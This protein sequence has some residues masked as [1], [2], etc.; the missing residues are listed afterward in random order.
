MRQPYPDLCPSFLIMIRLAHPSDPY[1]DWVI[2]QCPSF[3]AGRAGS[4]P[5]STPITSTAGTHFP[6]HLRTSHETHFTPRP[7]LGA[8]LPTCPY[9]PQPDSWA[10]R[11]VTGQAAAGGGGGGGGATRF[12]SWPHSPADQMGRT[13]RA[14]R[15]S[16]ARR[17]AAVTG[18]CARPLSEDRDVTGGSDD[19]VIDRSSQRVG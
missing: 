14:D 13:S 1:P 18:H 2:A 8:P 11:A 7:E 12:A 9:P 3:R 16:R 15:S 6:P 10:T 17:R 5:V 4:S 19:D